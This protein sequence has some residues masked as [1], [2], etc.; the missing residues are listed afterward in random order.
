[1][2][3]RRLRV[4]LRLLAT[5]EGGRTRRI[6]SGY[7]CQWRSDR[8]PGDNDAAVDLEYALAPGEESSAWLR[9]AVPKFWEDAVAVGDVLDGAQG[10]RVV[11]R[12]TVLE[13]FTN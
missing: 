3:P 1:M 5:A 11:A 7:R 12:A 6:Q 8:K 4:H 9:L 10:S 2:T 13:I